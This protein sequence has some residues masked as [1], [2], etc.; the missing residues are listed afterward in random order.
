MFRYIIAIAFV[1]L[2]L[3]LTSPMLLVLGIVGLFDR[4]TKDRISM[5][6]IQFAFRTVLVLTGTKVTVIGEE[7]IPTDRSVLF[8]G[9][10][11]SIFDTLITYSLMKTP[12]G[13]ISKKEMGMI[14][15]F[16][17]WMRNIRC[18]FLDRDDIKQG[19]QT[20]LTAIDMIKEGINVFIFPA[21]TRSKT[22]GEF[23]AF[24]GGSF[25]VATKS[26]CD[27]VPVSLH[28]LGDV[29]EDNK[30]KV[31]PVEVIVRF[32]EPI[33]TKDLPREVLKDIPTK[34]YEDVV[35]MYNE[36]KALID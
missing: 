22:E 11:R 31:K 34:A 21:G 25:K 26:G 4:K 23:P 15:I 16:R 28:Y 7:N 36:K 1:V 2:F 19:M 12:T 18:L 29:F 33:A 27:V 13:F 8:V 17:W 35:R 5:K 24:K 14:P 32:G 10:H 3:I 9:N 30:P 6:M 20:I